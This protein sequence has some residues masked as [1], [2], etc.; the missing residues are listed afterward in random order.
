MACGDGAAAAAAS[1]RTA[2]RAFAMCS[3]VRDAAACSSRARIASRIA[4]CSTIVAR[5]R[6][7]S[8]SER[9]R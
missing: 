8:E 9:N 3:A 1:R 5:R 2:A 7:G 6:S 4:S